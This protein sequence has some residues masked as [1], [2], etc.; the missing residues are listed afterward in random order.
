M[1]KGLAHYGEFLRQADGPGTYEKGSR[2]EHSD[3]KQTR[4]VAI[5][6]ALP[7]W[8]CLD[9]CFVQNQLCLPNGY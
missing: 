2:G 1:W 9:S 5:S 8:L 7:L 4:T 6:H 3:R